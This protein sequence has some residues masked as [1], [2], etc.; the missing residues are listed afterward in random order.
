MTGFVAKYISL[1]EGRMNL[2]LTTRLKYYLSFST[3]TEYLRPNGQTKELP[4]WFPIASP[5]TIDLSAINS[6]RGLI[7][8]ELFALL[9]VSQR[10][11]I[12]FAAYLDRNLCSDTLLHHCKN[13]HHPGRRSHRDHPPQSPCPECKPIEMNVYRL[14]T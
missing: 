2:L 4:K 12:S 10:K 13:S 9:D 11:I 3:N 14:P 1:F 6:E 7:A 8:Q 5:A